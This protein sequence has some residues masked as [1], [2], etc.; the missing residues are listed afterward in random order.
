ML[1]LSAWVGTFLFGFMG[2]T[3]SR[4]TCYFSSYSVLI[5]GIILLAITTSYVLEHVLEI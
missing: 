3:T 4:R 5:F 1:K 2:K